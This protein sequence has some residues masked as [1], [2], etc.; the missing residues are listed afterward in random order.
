M[1]KRETTLLALEEALARIVNNTPRRVPQARKLS[2]RSVETEAGLS[3][4]SAYYYPELIDKIATLK[5]GASSSA[6]IRRKVSGPD[7]WKEKAREAERLKKH[8]REENNELKALNAQ[9]AADQY[10]Q[11]S[12]LREALHKISEL[13]EVIEKLKKE[14]VAARRQNITHI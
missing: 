6:S 14:L 12:T 7:K 13:E 1:S 10:G 11:M 9:I 8:F 4:G 5:Q 3:N 2:A